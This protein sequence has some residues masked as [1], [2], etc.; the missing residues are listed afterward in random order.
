VTGVQTCA[1]PIFKQ[2]CRSSLVWTERD[3]I[4][5]GLMA[6][7]DKEFDHELG[8]RFG[9]HLG[10]IKRIGPRWSYPLSMQLAADYVAP[11]L[12]LVGDAAHVVHPLAGLGFNLGLRDA[13]ALVDVVR[14]AVH[15]GLDF[16]TVDV[17]E[18]YQK[19]RRFDN[20]SAA[21]MMD[22]L[23][24]VFSNASPTIRQLRDLGL[25]LVEK[26]PMAKRFFIEEA[27]GLSGDLPRLMRSSD[28]V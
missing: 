8:V 9:T 18:N 6:M 4:A 23:N 3:D 2:P 11:R 28:A 1:L 20:M 17:G 5:R 13:A 21:F 24:R 22:A 15:L 26:S 10:A 14:D 25:S 19:W 16:G 12:M 27:A 7:S